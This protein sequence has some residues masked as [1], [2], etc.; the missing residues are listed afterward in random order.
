MR[1]RILLTTITLL[2]MAILLTG[3]S[4]KGVLSEMLAKT[5][6][7]RLKLKEGNEKII[8]KTEDK[9]VTLGQQELVRGFPE[10]IPVYPGANVEASWQVTQEDQEGVTASFIT[11]DSLD[12]VERF[13]RDNLGTNGWQ[14]NNTMTAA[15]SVVFIAEKDQRSAWITLSQ[16]DNQVT[17]NIL[18]GTKGE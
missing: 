13:Y 1:K 4:V 15:D 17:I 10:D 11:Q 7:G 2:L 12:K 9:E 18:V 6:G 3:C 16:D 5:S 14:T 8:L